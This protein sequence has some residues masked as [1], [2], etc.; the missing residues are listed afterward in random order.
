MTGREKKR[1][2]LD[3]SPLAADKLDELVESTGS[4][5]RAEVVRRALALFDK[6]W[7]SQLEGGTLFIRDGQGGEQNLLIL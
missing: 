3:F 6:V 2:Q 1:I 5:S 4:A 7:T